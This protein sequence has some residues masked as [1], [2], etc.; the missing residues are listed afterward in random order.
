[1]SKAD[2]DP[3]SWDPIKLVE[4]ILASG[5]QMIFCDKDCLGWCSSSTGMLRSSHEKEMK[6]KRCKS[7]TNHEQLLD[8]QVAHRYAMWIQ[9][10]LVL[11]IYYHEHNETWHFFALL[12]AP[13]KAKCWILPA[14]NLGSP[15]QSCA[16]FHLF[17]KCLVLY[18]F[19][20]AY[21]TSNIHIATVLHTQGHLYSGQ[22]G[23]TTL[24]WAQGKDSASK[25]LLS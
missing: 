20:L 8:F 10:H 18:F 9:A 6:E 5:P 15:Q 2:K 3:T 7:K 12:F 16:V 4:M 19:P 25:S 24:V 17:R 21:S 1:M 14:C 13:P 11:S 23:E 22:I